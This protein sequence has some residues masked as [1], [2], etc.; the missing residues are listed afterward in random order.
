M[1]TTSSSDADR[2]P[3]AEPPPS[4][5]ARL[6]WRVYAGATMLALAAA[7]GVAALLGDDEGEPEGDRV[8]LTPDDTAPEQAAAGAAPSLE[9]EFVNPDRSTSTLADV[10]AD[11]G[12]PLVVNFFSTT[13]PPCITE[14]PALQAAS[15]RLGDR[16]TFVGLAVLDRPEAAAELVERTGV[17]YRTGRDPQGELFNATGA[18]GLPTT[19]LIDADG[20]V[21]VVHTGALEEDDVLDLVADELGVE[22]A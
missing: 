22:A 6:S 5:R 11:T 12:T 13:C 17:T 15:E 16:V 3:P 4:A 18:L 14:M 10:V 2:D 20:T 19:M 7:L 9:V 21:R 8:V 1:V